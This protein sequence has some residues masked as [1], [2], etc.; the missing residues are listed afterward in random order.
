[1]A[2]VDGPFNFMD[3]TNNG[4]SPDP[5]QPCSSDSLCDPTPINIST[6]AATSINTSAE[7]PKTKKAKMTKNK[8]TVVATGGRLPEPCPLP[9]ISERTKDII[10]ASGYERNNRF[11]LLREAV[12]FYEGI[13]P[14]PTSEEYTAMAKTF[15]HEYPELKDKGEKYWVSVHACNM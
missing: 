9:I 13:C 3:F 4:E 7:G 12:T 2:V 8:V 14:N 11:F 15:C 5:D 6:E 1:M 10:S